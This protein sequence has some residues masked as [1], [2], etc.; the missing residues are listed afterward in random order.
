MRTGV[1]RVGLGNNPRPR[2]LLRQRPH[3][4]LSG[5]SAKGAAALSSREQ[6]SGRLDR[7]PW[8]VS[9]LFLW[10]CEL[11]RIELRHFEV[12]RISILGTWVNRFL[13]RSYASSHSTVSSTSFASGRTFSDASVF[14][15][16]LMITVS[17]S[18]P[19]RTMVRS[20]PSS[21]AHQ[22]WPWRR[23]HKG[24]PI[25]RQSSL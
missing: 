24:T 25:P 15:H 9:V 8:R 5:R 17:S 2:E 13:R 16:T 10:S 1:T 19:S 18:T 14:D 6:L 23:G 21:S 20:N 22:W 7:D 4:R 11:F 3:E 12:R